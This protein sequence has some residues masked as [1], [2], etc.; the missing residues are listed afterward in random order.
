MNIVNIKIY[1]R[2]ISEDGNDST[3]FF[4]SGRYEDTE[5]G[6]VLFYDEGNG[7][8]YESCKVKITITGNLVIIERSGQVNTTLKIEEG[9]KHYC[10]YATPYGEIS[11]GITAYEVEN[12]LSDEGGKLRLRYC[13]DVNSDFISENEMLITIS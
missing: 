13:I 5:N 4:T 10:V 3:E 12:G 1:T 11:M 6:Y 7:I 2:I 9:A 8:G